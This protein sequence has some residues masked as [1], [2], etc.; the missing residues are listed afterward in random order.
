[1]IIQDSM[2]GELNLLNEDI[3]MFRE[4]VISNSNLKGMVLTKYPLKIRSYSSNPIIGFGLKDKSKD[5]QNLKSIYNQFKQIAKANGD[6]DSMS[7]F[8]SLEHERMIKVKRLGFDSLLL[9]LNWLSNNHGKS[10]IR[11]VIFTLITAFVF[12]KLYL[13]N[14]GQII[15]P[16][17]IYKYYVQFITSYP[18]L[19]LDRFGDANSSWN[20]NLVIWFARIFISYGIY[21]TV[22]SFR[23]Y[24]KE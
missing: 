22:S 5:D 2:V 9:T 20:V 10:W 4:I 15:T 23:K 7:R 17:D 12:F 6:I 19:E 21:Q 3:N 8:K 13:M 1:M 24:G 14:V 11:S 18:K 16:P